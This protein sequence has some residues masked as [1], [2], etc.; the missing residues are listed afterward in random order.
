MGFFFL[1]FFFL[2][3]GASCSGRHLHVKAL[4]VLWHRR[5]LSCL[6]F[7][8]AKDPDCEGTSTAWCHAE[9]WR[10]TVQLLLLGCLPLWGLGT[11]TQCPS[12]SRSGAHIPRNTHSAPALA[13]EHCVLRFSSRS[14]FYRLRVSSVYHKGSSSNVVKNTIHRIV[15][16]GGL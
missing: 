8:L 16:R 12:Q 1:S 9:Q 15:E 11:G 2:T 6:L 5:F 10:V 13:S 4:A 3:F 14:S 7:L